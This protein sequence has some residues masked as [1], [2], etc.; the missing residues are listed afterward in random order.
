MTVF[1]LVRHGETDWNRE[2][3]YTGQS[4]IPLNENGRQQARQAAEQL[5]DLHPHVI[6]SSDLSRALETAQIISQVVSLPVMIDSRLREINQGEWEGLHVDEIKNRFNGL[7]YTREK[8]P[9][10]VSSPGGE[11]IGDVY[12]RVSAALKDMLHDYSDEKVVV[13][14]HGVVLAIMRVIA[15]NEPIQKVFDFIPENAIIHQIEIGRNHGQ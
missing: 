3:K 9:F 12:Q 13:T 2:G 14:A 15:G 8:D 5:L 4:D 10:N 6:Y 1:F 11:T 7:F